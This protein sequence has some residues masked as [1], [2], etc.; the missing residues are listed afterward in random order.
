MIDISQKGVTVRR[1]LAQGMIY[2]N[3]EGFKTVLTG[4]S[5]KGDLW[6]AAKLAGIGAAKLTPSL[7][8]YCHPLALEKVQIQFEINKSKRCVKVTAEILC[9]GKTGVEMESLA[10]VS[11]A[12]L[13]LYDMM[14][15]A[16]QD[17]MIT[18]ICLEH[19]SGGKKGTYQR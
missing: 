6:E 14:K 10:A 16:G 5:P 4:K 12:C 13:S 17:M 3:K 19:K 18:D 7:L 9:S 11:A 8:P 15:W 2:F 1:A